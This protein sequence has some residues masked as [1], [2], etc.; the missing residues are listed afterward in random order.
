[1]TPSPDLSLHPRRTLRATGRVGWA[2]CA[3]LAAMPMT[4]AVAQ[5]HSNGQA[6]GQTMGLMADQLPKAPDPTTAKGFARLI[7]SGNDYE[8][9]ASQRAIEMAH[10]PDV[11]AFARRMV[12][13]HKTI[14]KSIDAAMKQAGI[15]RQTG[16]DKA[17]R[18][19]MDRLV[20]AQDFEQLYLEQQLTHHQKTVGM[21][22]DYAHSGPKGAMHDLAK[23]LLPKLLDDLRRVRQLV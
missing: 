23:L 16:M 15:Q 3:A 5:T 4:P 14:A 12:D 21:V 8:I 19:R 9:A 2:L 18:A 10:D 1:M 6:P 7:A 17:D 20:S 13:V 22:E 11:I